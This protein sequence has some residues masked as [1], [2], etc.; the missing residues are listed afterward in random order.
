[1]ARQAWE[2]VKARIADPEM[3]MVVCDELNIMLRYDYLPVD[4]VLEA[5]TTRAEDKP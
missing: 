4:A 5:I 1:M 3:D 2:V